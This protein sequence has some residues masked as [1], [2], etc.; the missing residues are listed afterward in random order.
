MKIGDYD[1]VQTCSGCPEQYDV[2]DK[3]KNQVG[4]VRLRHGHLRADCPDCGGTTVYEADI[5][6]NWTGSFPKDK[7]RRIHLNRI[8]MRIERFGYTIVCPTC[9][10]TQGMTVE[11]LDELDKVGKAVFECEECDRYFLVEDDGDGLFT[12]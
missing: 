3:D 8:A 1:F 9:G 11:A 12:H 4:Y 5:G 6:D 10:S 2:Y 7:D